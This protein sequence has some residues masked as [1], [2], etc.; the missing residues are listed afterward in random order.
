MLSIPI[1]LCGANR[2]YRVHKYT[3]R[4]TA[5]ELG[6]AHARGTETYSTSRHLA[7]EKER[8]GRL[9]DTTS[10]GYN[11]KRG[12]LKMRAQAAGLTN[13]DDTTV[14]AYPHKGRLLLIQWLFLLRGAQRV[15]RLP[16]PPLLLLHPAPDINKHSYPNI[17]Q[18]FFILF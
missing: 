10:I 16:R 7:R 9:Y 11:I 4:D 12:Q 13:T 5:H 3:P 1:F 15:G 8:V 17:R 14:L 18:L 2:S 6:L